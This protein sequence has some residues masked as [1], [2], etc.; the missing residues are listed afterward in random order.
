MAILGASGYTGAELTRLLLSHPEVEISV[1]TADRN[2]GNSYKTVFPHFTPFNHL[3]KLLKWEEA[4]EDIGNCDVAFCCLPH[5]TSQEIILKLS[6]HPSL[7]VSRISH[8]ISF[9]SHVSYRNEIIDL[10]AD[11]RLSNI[12]TY[13]KVLLVD[14]LS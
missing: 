10:S 11:F 12:N 7:K 6:E 3:P 9:S 2:A 13:F 5:G 14:L 8:V 1:L 4:E